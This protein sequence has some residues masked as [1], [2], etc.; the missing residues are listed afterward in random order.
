LDFILQLSVY[1][2]CHCVYSMYNSIDN[3]LHCFSSPVKYDLQMVAV[4]ATFFS[5]YCD[6]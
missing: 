2:I 4:V 6:V 1:V 5:W 3:C